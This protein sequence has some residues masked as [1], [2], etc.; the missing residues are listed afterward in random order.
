M[1]TYLSLGA[2]LGAREATINQA[3]HLISQQAGTLLQ[4]SA[5]FYS[6]PWGFESEHEF[7]NLCICID[8]PLAPLDLLH[9]LQSIEI[10]LGRQR[11]P[12][13]PI[14][15]IYHDRPID[16]DIILYEGVELHTP[17]LT[18][19]HPLYRQR[20]F[21]LIPLRELLPSLPL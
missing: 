13:S 4:R 5:F 7:C 17:E 1:K 19:P 3:V 2:N 10:H 15:N 16:I 14:T 18:I 8:T 6:Q 21:V 11:P 12:Q 20:D 9:T